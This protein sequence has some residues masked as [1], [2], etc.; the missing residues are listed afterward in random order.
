[1][2][3]PE[4]GRTIQSRIK[5]N[6]PQRAAPKSRSQVSQPLGR[7]QRVLSGYGVIPAQSPTRGAS[8]ENF[9]LGVKRRGNVEPRNACP[10]EVRVEKAVYAVNRHGKLATSVDSDNAKRTERS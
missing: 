5:S 7:N 2:I 8:L 10:L 1:V 4:L 6:F 3:R 9:D